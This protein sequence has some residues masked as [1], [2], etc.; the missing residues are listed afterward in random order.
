MQLSKREAK[1]IIDKLQ[2]DHR[3]KTHNYGFLKY[4]NKKIL[5]VYFSHGKGDMPGNVPDKF[6]QSLK[7]NRSDFEDLKNCPLSRADYIEI[8]KSKGI[9]DKE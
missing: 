6:R 4:N 2:I 9:I 7:I 5:P 3:N 8:L 1:K